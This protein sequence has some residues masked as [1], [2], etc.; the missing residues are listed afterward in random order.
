MKTLFRTLLFLALALWVGAECF[1]P[2]VA[3][4][5]FSV[6]SPDTHTAGIIVGHLLKILHGIG[7]GAGMVAV[8]VLA[9]MA[10]LKHCRSRAAVLPICLLAVAIALTL[11]SQYAIT[12]VME[13]DRIAAGGSVDAA[14][15]T[16]PARIDFK[17]LHK[18]SEHTEGLILLLAVAA[19]I[20][21]ASSESLRS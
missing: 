6:L 21:T 17:R 1:F 10:A 18:R 4:T 12:P 2:F 8:F 19:L 13:R 9:R 11:Y 14:A 15:P 5:V 7:F 20:A 16:N 3:A